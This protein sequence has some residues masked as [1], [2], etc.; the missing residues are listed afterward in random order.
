MLPVM[1]WQRTETALPTT[2]SGKQVKVLLFSPGWA[3]PILGLYTYWEG[4]IEGAELD[5]QDDRYYAREG[6]AP[7]F[8]AAVALPGGCG[9]QKGA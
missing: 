3:G 1:A 7:E 5:Q 4:S 2:E 6:A 8:W 9:E